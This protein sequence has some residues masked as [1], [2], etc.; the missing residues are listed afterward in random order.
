MNEVT[1]E[2]LM[3][4]GQ[5][6]NNDKHNVNEPVV[7]GEPECSISKSLDSTM[8]LAACAVNVYLVKKKKYLKE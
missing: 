7:A 6:V 8:N 3:T 4:K 2:E 1:N 5:K